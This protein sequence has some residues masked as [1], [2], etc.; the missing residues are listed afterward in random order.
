MNKAIEIS[1]QKNYTIIKILLNEYNIYNTAFIAK[2]GEDAVSSISTPY[3]IIDF[4]EV[5]YIDSSGIGSLA[6]IKKALN[7]KGIEMICVGMIENII[8]VFKITN[9]ESLFKIYD[10]L[11]EGVNFIN[12]NL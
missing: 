1:V 10:S 5:T 2:S 6:H 9:T 4:N 3:V 12:S 8:K 7:N 11:D